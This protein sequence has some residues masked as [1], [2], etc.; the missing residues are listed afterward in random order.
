MTDTPTPGA[1]LPGDE[2]AATRRNTANW[3]NS[4]VINRSIFS[5]NAAL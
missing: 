5:S 1:A 2:L 3:I 4:A